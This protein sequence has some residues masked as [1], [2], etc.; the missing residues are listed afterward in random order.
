M[1]YLKTVI[2]PDQSP[3]IIRSAT[4]DDAEAVLAQMTAANGETFYMGRYPDEITVTPE[5]EA[6]ILKAMQDSSDSVL[7]CAEVN[8]QIV[9]TAGI[10]PIS[11]YSKCRHRCE[12]GVSVLRSHWHLGIGSAMTDAA[13]VCARNAGYTQVELDVVSE[14]LH[15]IHLYLKKGFEIYGTLSHA[16]R[17]QDG[18]FLDTYLMRAVV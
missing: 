14:N 6:A 2:L 4:P 11:T 7:L 3:C 17:L 8:G 13:M 16:F 15:A 5:K 9:S 12:F 10:S 1:D 18:R